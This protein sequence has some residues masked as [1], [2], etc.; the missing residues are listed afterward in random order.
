MS[1]AQD[2]YGTDIEFEPLRHSIESNYPA[3]S[4]LIRKSMAIASRHFLVRGLVVLPIWEI[5]DPFGHVHQI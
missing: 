2:P 3:V 1:R 5:I 4:A